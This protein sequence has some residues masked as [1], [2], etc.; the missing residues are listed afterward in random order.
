MAGLVTAEK[1]VI[2]NPADN[3]GYT[4]EQRALAASI[5]SA[6]PVADRT[7]ADVVAAAMAADGRP[8][9]NANPLVVFRQDF[10]RIEIKTAS[11]WG[12]PPQGIVSYTEMTANSGTLTGAVS[13]IKGI[14]AFT[15]IAGRSYKITV[16]SGYYLTTTGSTWAWQFG[17]C[18]IADS[19]TLTTGITP[20]IAW[21]DS[22]SAASEGRRFGMTRLYRPGSTGILQLKL[23]AQRVTGAA[24]AVVVA[25][26]NDPLFLL[27]EDLGVT[28]GL[29]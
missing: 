13:V 6:V 9:T 5:R 8:V 12:G 3:Y 17:T 2:A 11:G 23:T 24:N 14:A 16:E 19:P 22:V 18:N 29:V 27:V 4:A 20:I 21:T 25:S 7:E 1:Q 26:T 28:Q 15:F 10:E